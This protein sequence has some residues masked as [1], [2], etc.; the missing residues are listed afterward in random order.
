MKYTILVASHD[1]EFIKKLENFLQSISD[2]AIDLKVIYAYSKEDILRYMEE[3]ILSLLFLD[4]SVKNILTDEFLSQ[5]RSNKLFEHKPIIARIASYKQLDLKKENC[6]IFLKSTPIEELAYKIKS[7][8]IKEYENS[9]LISTIFDQNAQH[10]QQMGFLK[11]R[12]LLIFTHELKTPLNAIISFSNHINRGL[13]KEKISQKKIDKFIELSNLIKVNG[14]VL[15]SEITTLLDV[16]KIKEN[17][18]TYLKEEISLDSLLN[19]IINKYKYLYSKMVC[20]EIDT[21]NISTDANAFNHIFENLYSNA[22]KYSNSKVN[23]EL[24]TI[25]DEFELI[26]EDDG[27]GID[28]KDKN[29]VFELFEQTEDTTLTREK[30]GTGIGLYIVKLLCD[31]LNYK[32][33][34]EKS[35]LGGAKF[36]LRGKR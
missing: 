6:S 8:I 27:K 11:D 14:E 9:A 5:V 4:S 1:D 29:R 3:D 31:E 23:I 24:K 2:E 34:V 15:L 32:I 13:Q 20:S 10:Q 33:E 30:E 22:L 12:M 36:I 26:V 21:L 7:I 25:D 18:M 28:L 16:A 35:H 17:K 19:K